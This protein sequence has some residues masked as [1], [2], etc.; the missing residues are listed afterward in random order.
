M[1]HTRLWI[2]SALIAC[3][4]V[5]SFLVSILRAQRAEAPGGSL[6]LATEAVPAAVTVKDVFR[7][8]THTISGSVVVPD[9]CTTPTTESSLGGEAPDSQSI[10]LDLSY[11]EDVGVC[12]QVPTSVSFTTTI[13]APAGLPIIVMVNGVIAT[14]SGQ[15]TMP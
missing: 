3:I 8:G 9:A 11:P 10:I 12:L 15:A 13:A 5:A 7:K 14:S 1:N 6:P 4:I 2:V